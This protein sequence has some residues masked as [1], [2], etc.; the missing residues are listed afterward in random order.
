MKRSSLLCL[1]SDHFEKEFLFATVADRD[2]KTLKQSKI[3]IKFEGNQFEINDEV[4]YDMVESLAFF[5]AYRHVLTTLQVSTLEN[6]A[7]TYLNIISAEPRILP[8]KCSS[9]DAKK[10]PC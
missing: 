7:V 9:A 8:R 2:E 6:T 10:W 3:G 4:K 5:E 1:S